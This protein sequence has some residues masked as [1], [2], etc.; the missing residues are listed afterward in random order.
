[1]AEF[2]LPPWLTPAD[3]AAYASRGMSMGIEL[4]ARE[5]AQ[6]FAEQQQLREQHLAEMKLAR[7]DAEMGLRAQE[8]SIKAQ[9]AARRA[10]AQAEYRAAIEAGEDPLKTLLR[11]GPEMGSQG[12]A[13]AAAIRAGMQKPAPTWRYEDVPGGGKVMISSEGRVHNVAA[14]PRERDKFEQ[15]TQDVAGV[16]VLGNKNLSTG[17]FD[18]IASAMQQPGRM[19]QQTKAELAGVRREISQI[20]KDQ[21]YVMDPNYKP[22]KGSSLT[23]EL[24]SAQRTKYLELKR[25]EAEL[26]AGGAQAQGSGLRILSIRPKAG[27]DEEASD[28]QPEPDLVATP[29]DDE[30]Y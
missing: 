1:M 2:S 23:P 16:P 24:L 22:K 19:T 20:E 11:F 28:E 5:A 6:R 8:I 7:M 9:M 30:E 26:I 14:P 27:S 29:A 13:E 17:R 18:P 10:Q 21:S 4:G 25:R 12:T 3:P 15:V